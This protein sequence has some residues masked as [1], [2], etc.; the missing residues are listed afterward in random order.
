[1]F[2]HVQVETA[3]VHGAVVVPRAAVLR[4]EDG[5]SVVVVDAANIARRIPVTTGAGDSRGIAITSG[6]EPDAKVVTSSAVPVHDGSVVRVT[7]SKL[8]RTHTR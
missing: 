2:A 1:M 5:T 6:L 3:R 4:G 8:N 7:E